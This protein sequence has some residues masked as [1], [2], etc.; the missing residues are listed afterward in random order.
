M[1]ICVLKQLLSV[2]LNL[3]NN[4]KLCISTFYRVGTLGL[5][6]YSEIENYFKTLASKKK[7]DKH[8]LIGDLNLSSV[9]WPEGLTTCDLQNQFLE[10]IL[11]DLGHSQ[12]I[13]EPTHRSGNT[14][15]LLFT[16]VPHLVNNV[17][18]LDHN[19]ACLSDHFGITFNIKL[20][21]SR[22]KLSRPKVYN[23]TKANW[24]G[25]NYELR[26]VNWQSIIGSQDPHVAWPVFKSVL[27]NLSDKHIPKKSKVPVPAALV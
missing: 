22:K 13:S 17:T 6:N 7:L 25:L 12:F 3:P 11:G 21:V 2:I 9:T 27:T 18:V 4:K 16:N 1:F 8:I 14:L 19:E 10:F 20:D 26:K 24:R 15:D 23:Y 5:E